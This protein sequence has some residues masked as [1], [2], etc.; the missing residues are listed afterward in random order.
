MM[1][2]M[3][4]P[5]DARTDPANPSGPIGIMAAMP[6]ELQALL[7][8]MPDESRVQ[9]GGR[10]FWRGHLGGREVVAVL[11]GIGKVAAATTATLLADAFG[12]SQLW[13]TGVAGGLGADVRVGDVV[14]ASA[15]LQHDL[16]AS[17]LFPRHEVP[18]LGVSRL[19]PPA[20]LV[21]QVA[22]A[23]A[24]ALSP[25]ALAPGG[26]L[27]HIHL[28][29]LGLHAPRVHTGLIVSGDQFVNSAEDADTLR[30]HLPDVLAVEMEGAAVAQVCVAFGLPYAVVRTVS[31]RADA[32]AHV[33]FE[34]FVR[35]VAS[36]YSLAIAM[37][38]LKALPRVAPDGAVA[39]PQAHS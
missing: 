12:V 4:H 28:D 2:G 10:E 27:S 9:R 31:D 39:A 5:A 19:H 34:R 37:A 35:S 38:L 8:L 29:T 24:E 17:P 30:H 33:D 18:G 7:D 13:F 6:Q 32:S 1:A 23:V 26:P 21:T 22:D 11:S 14:V 36:P 20:A 15:L 25:Q 3:P 16:D